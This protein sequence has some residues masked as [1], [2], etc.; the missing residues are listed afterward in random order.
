MPDRERTAPP[1][2]RMLQH[3]SEQIAKG[4]SPAGERIPRERELMEDWNVSKATAN[5]V[6][7]E[8]KAAGLVETHMGVGVVVKDQPKPTGIGPR[9]MWARIKSN[10]RIRLPSER[11]E[12]NI[13]WCDSLDA[14][15]HIVAALNGTSQSGELLRRARVIYRD[16]QPYSMATSWFHPPMLSQAGPGVI[17]RLAEDTPIEEGTPQYIASR[18][19][20][21]LGSGVDYV[22]AIEADPNLAGTFGVS[23]GSPVMRI[24]STIYAGEDFPVEVG[25]YL[26]PAGSGVSYS[27]EL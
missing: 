14:P 22:E 13:D 6:V 8:L 21:D 18:L 12:R 11:S 10:G 26:Y 19:G 5:K 15:A 2:R 27:Y 9:D 17:E 24:V 20:L 7:A 25:E 3:I 16:E 1:Y 23:E 4:E